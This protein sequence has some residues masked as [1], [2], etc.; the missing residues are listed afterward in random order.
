MG[1]PCWPWEGKDSDTQ[2]GKEPDSRGC[3]QIN[4]NETRGCVAS[5]QIAKVDPLVRL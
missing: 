4:V 5:V 1:A 2:R 3:G